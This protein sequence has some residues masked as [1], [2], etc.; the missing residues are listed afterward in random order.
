MSRSVS[1]PAS[2]RIVGSDIGQDLCSGDGC[3]Q[4]LQFIIPDRISRPKSPEERKLQRRTGL[5][6]NVKVYVG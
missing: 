6:L 2:N 1:R 3:Q 4:D 5:G